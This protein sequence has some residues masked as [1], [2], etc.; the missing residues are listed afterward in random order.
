MRLAMGIATAAAY[1]KATSATG[2]V[3]ASDVIALLRSEYVP[4]RV[5]GNVLQ[6]HEPDVYAGIERGAMED[7]GRVV[8]PTVARRIGYRGRLRGIIRE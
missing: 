8:M 3:S 7:D 4:Y 2:T 6:G 1:S 5:L